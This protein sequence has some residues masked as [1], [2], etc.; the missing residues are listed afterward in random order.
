MYIM[1]IEIPQDIL[2][3]MHKTQFEHDEYC[4]FDLSITISREGNIVVRDLLGVWDEPGVDRLPH[5]AWQIIRKWWASEL[6][7]ME[8]Q[9]ERT[10]IETQ[11]DELQAQLE[12]LKAKAEKKKWLWW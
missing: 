8:A 11:I 6:E 5:T 1:K 12:S 3:I 2:D 10:A 4:E 7:N 9:K